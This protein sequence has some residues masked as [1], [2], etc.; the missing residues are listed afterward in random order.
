MI[1]G[2]VI[3]TGTLLVYLYAVSQNAG[4]EI[5]RTMVF[6]VL[7]AANIFLT[8]VNRSF[9]YSIFTTLQYKNNLVWLIIGITASLAGITLLVKPVSDFFEFK[10][11]SV[12]QLG[13]CVAMGF[14]SVMWYE[15]V[16]WVKRIL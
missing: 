8:L 13:I 15:L 2:L 16:K 6:T 4:E 12:L 5:T 1:Q 11:L 3:T 9:Y 7:I 10:Q 14:V